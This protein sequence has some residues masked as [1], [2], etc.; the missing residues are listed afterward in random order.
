MADVG[1]VFLQSGGGGN[2]AARDWK[3]YVPMPNGYLAFRDMG[4]DNLNNGM[5]S[6]AMA[7]QWGTGNV[8]IGTTNPSEKLEVAGKTKTTALQVITGATS[9]YVLQSDASGN[10]SWV[11]PVSL[12]VT[13]PTGATGATGANAPIG[14]FTH[15]LGESLNGGIV[16]NLYKGSDGLE[17][18]L[19]VA[20]TES[21]T[22]AWQTAGTLVNANRSEDGAYNTTLMTGSPAA[23]YITSLGSGWYLPSIDELSLL[24]YN[25]YYV[26]KALRAG[27]NTLLS[28]ADYY[29]SSTEYNASLAYVFFFGFG[30]SNTTAKTSSYTIRGIRAF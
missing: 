2:G 1:S 4:F 14:G 5:S 23:T 9:G 16:F 21:T 22:T 10:G 24:Y 15:Y 6:D 30:S 29:W 28:N 17:H 27:G 7:I 18:G 12:G 3:I 25:H 26:Q 20:L 8:G 19:I 13:G 11:A